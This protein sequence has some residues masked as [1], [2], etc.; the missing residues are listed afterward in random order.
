[1][2]QLDDVVHSSV[3]GERL[4]EAMHRFEC[5]FQYITTV[6]LQVMYKSHFCLDQCVGLTAVLKHTKTQIHRT[7]LRLF[8]AV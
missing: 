1:M 6:L 8:R 7:S 5:R 4:E 2:M 3:K